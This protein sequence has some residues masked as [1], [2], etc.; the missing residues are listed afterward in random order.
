MFEYRESLEL[1]A[2]DMCNGE[3]ILR[4]ICGDSVCAWCDGTG[5]M[6]AKVVT[7]LAVDPRTRVEDRDQGTTLGVDAMSPLSSA[8][9]VR[10]ALM[11]ADFVRLSSMRDVAAV[12]VE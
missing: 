5:T 10:V 4:D 11:G 1:I 9:L 3:R 2:C 6:E 12:D 8:A 7:L